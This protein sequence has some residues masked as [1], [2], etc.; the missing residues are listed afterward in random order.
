M[1]EIINK[2]IHENEVSEI[3]GNFADTTSY[4]KT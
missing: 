4:F 1:S 3:A 2:A